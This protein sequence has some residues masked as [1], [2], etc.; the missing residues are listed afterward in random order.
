[1]RLRRLQLRNVKSYGDEPTTI[2]F[3]DGVNLVAGANGAG[4]S[5]QIESIG[6]AL[7]DVCPYTREEFVRRG[8]KT[9]V[10]K[11]WFEDDGEEFTVERRFGGSDKWTAQEGDGVIHE[12]AVDVLKFLCDRFKAAD[13]D[14]LRKIF[15]NIV[16]VPQGKFTYLFNETPANRKKALDSII[17]V[18]RYRDTAD[19]RKDIKGQLL[20]AAIADADRRIAEANAWIDANKEVP[21]RFATASRRLAELKS[22]I[23]DLEAHEEKLETRAKEL[24]DARSQIEGLDRHISEL[25]IKIE[26]TRRAYREA[27]EAVK[28]AANAAGVIADCGPGHEAWLEADK[29]FASLDKRRTTR[30]DA[31]HRTREAASNAR[32]AEAALKEIE[33]ALKGLEEREKAESDA[34]ARA[35]KELTAA[36]QEAAHA[37]KEADAAR[38]DHETHVTDVDAFSAAYEEA[39]RLEA[40]LKELG[41]QRCPILKE[42]C[43]RL[44]PDIADKRRK[45]LDAK[46]KELE[47]IAKRLDRDGDIDLGRFKKVARELKDGLRAAERELVKI[48]KAAE[49]AA[50]D[51]KAAAQA[52]KERQKRIETLDAER[53]KLAATRKAQEKKR[54]LSK[55][56]FESL[57]A[58]LTEFSTLDAELAAARKKRD[59]NRDAHDRWLKSSQAAADIERRRERVEKL[60]RETAE[61]DQQ[62]AL[63]QAERGTIV[64]DASE[65]AMCAAELADVQG[66]LGS[67]R[68]EAEVLEAEL[69]RLR[70]IVD[71]ID[72]RKASRDA[73]ARELRSLD[74]F[75][76]ILDDLWKILRD[77]GPRISRRLLAGI[78]AR[79][80]RIFGVLSGEPARL[81]WAEDYEL[82]LHRGPE[83]VPFRAMSGGEQMAAALS[84]QMAMARTFARSA[85][86][87]FDEPTTH[88]DD[89][90]RSRLARAVKEA[91]QE[92]QFTQVFVVSHDDTFSPFVDHE[93]SVRKDPSRG[94]QIT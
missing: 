17:D 58:L 86:C 1:M 80:N 71:E 6:F 81:A 18:D 75:R 72:R 7:F 85:F 50:R 14:Q 70:I 43:D 90:R 2:D 8:A 56:D 38:R 66:D 88:L 15:S 24:D 48:E 42:S 41:N 19:A 21:D 54:D 89:A 13:P 64:Y 30:D 29:A 33:S 79:A 44:S 73:A 37:A 34:V 67:S 23:G 53:D 74:R 92:A 12:G 93:I 91:Q 32:E 49:G 31:V 26:G 11:V 83:S 35:W 69:G 59:E 45:A 36:K 22:R 10:I 60:V 9:G 65:S 77:A 27:A 82:R 87:V 76:E 63:A 3:A 57:T 52:H 94:S 20:T 51:A 5:T 55:R 62:H 61:L 4:K 78:S 47:A 40:E 68:K 84:V 25:S 39:V 28:E 16:G 46:L